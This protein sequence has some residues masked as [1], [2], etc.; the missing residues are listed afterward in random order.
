MKKWVQKTAGLI[1]SS[2]LALGLGVKVHAVSDEETLPVPS[3]TE[4]VEP[5]AET[6]STESQSAESITAEADL[7]ETDSS[8]IIQ[9]EDYPIE[10]ESV[11]A[12]PAEETILSETEPLEESESAE[13][14]SAEEIVLSE[15]V[16]LEEDKPAETAS[17]EETVLSETVLL[18]EDKP[19]ET[20]S[21]EETVLS[22]ALPLGENKPAEAVPAGDAKPVFTVSVEKSQPVESASSQPLRNAPA[23]AVA[24]ADP[25]AATGISSVD[26]ADEPEEDGLSSRS[27][28]KS[29]DDNLTTEITIGG[30]DVS[31]RDGWSYNETTGQVGLVNFDHPETSIVSTG[32]GAL[33]IVASGCNRILSIISEGNVNVTGTGL[34][35]LDSVSLGENSNFYLH[36]PLDIY[37]EGTGSVAVFFKTGDNQY[38]L[39]NGGVVGIL[40]EQY[41]I[42]G[43]DLVVPKNSSLFVNSGGTVY[44][45]DT[46]EILFRY[47]GDE[48]EALAQEYGVTASPNEEEC[49]H[50]IDE[51]HGSLTI[52]SGASLTV[53]NGGTIRMESTQGIRS[54]AQI[55]APV[56]SAENGGAIV[57]N[58]A[59]TGDGRVELS[60]NSSLSGSG[61]IEAR[62]VSV[63]SLDALSDCSVTL[64]SEEIRISG[65]GTISNLVLD[66]SNVFLD[67]S[68]ATVTVSN[69]VNSGS[70]SIINR[71]KLTLGSVTN[72]GHITLFSDTEYPSADSV[73]DLSGPVSGGTLQLTGGV[74]HLRGQFE[75]QNNAAMSCDH[76]IVYDHIG[77][78]ASFDAPLIVSPGQVTAPTLSGGRYAVPLVIVKSDYTSSFARGT[79]IL[80]KENSTVYFSQNNEGKY[81]LNLG[82]ASSYDGGENPLAELLKDNKIVSVVVEL[83]ELDSNDNL[84]FRFEAFRSWKL[85]LVN[86][87]PVFELGSTYLVR[88]TLTEVYPILPSATLTS[89]STSFTGT[90]ILGGSGAGSL[91]GGVGNQLFFGSN[92]SNQGS[93]TSDTDPADSDTTSP[94]EDDLGSPSAE[95]GGDPANTLPLRIIVTE[96]NDYYKVTG[97]YGTQEIIVPGQAMTVN[98][99]FHLPAGWNSNAIYVVF[100]H[101]DG[102]LTVYKAYY[103]ASTGVLSFDTDLTGTFA[104]VCFP[105]DGEPF[106]DGFYA[107]LKDLAIIRKLPVCR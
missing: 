48:G 35:L 43:V 30:K 66:S 28:A 79:T 91:N 78:S 53:E 20:V 38:T 60:D 101:D 94:A 26:G 95:T 88:I 12:A 73:F 33:E 18:E 4:A 87:P 102:T 84:S 3:Q 23:R 45:K 15:T 74:F 99:E 81:V 97:F 65:S 5:A 29:G 80:S 2:F 107:A 98:M 92:T 1:L 31:E 22:E 19:A 67:F 41:T 11:E 71:D 16:L 68:G 77:S 93:D 6:Q 62:G 24:S 96:I 104:L 14:V 55:S 105:Y 106:S 89:T 46:H 52:G 57:V 39:V 100:R 34:L 61:S 51:T 32:P 25:A 8:D 13:T 54:W 40:D 103:S 44:E 7:T 90:G 72:S 42:T 36:T 85:D 63:S 70:S 37:E 9:E 50:G 56:V 10:D 76:V 47:T 58:G 83:Q 86:Q 21:A 49:S 59:I 69:L 64:Q 82:E 27:L 17:A 75:L